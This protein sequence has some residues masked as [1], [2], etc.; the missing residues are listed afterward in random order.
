MELSI[1]INP[2]SCGSKGA[3]GVKIF[4]ATKYCRGSCI[5][6]KFL[7]S[8]VDNLQHQI[9]VTQVPYHPLRTPKLADNSG[10]Y[11][12]KKHEDIVMNFK[13]LLLQWKMSSF[14]SLQEAVSFPSP[15]CS[16][17]CC[18]VFLF[19]HYSFL[20]LYSSPSLFPFPHIFPEIIFPHSFLQTL[21]ACSMSY[22]PLL[23]LFP[24]SRSILSV[25]ICTFNFFLNL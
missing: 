20:S 19:P 3:R 24:A 5:T 10:F 1:N 2:I 9:N 11:F 12:T 21:I 22:S 6:K 23:Y 14:S 18:P 8:Q 15:P 13:F 4:Q 16:P 17:I 25:W 7:T